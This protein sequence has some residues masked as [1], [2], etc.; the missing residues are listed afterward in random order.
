MSGHQNLLKTMYVYNF[1]AGF[2]FK[3]NLSMF[4]LV[5]LYIFVYVYNVKMHFSNGSYRE[6]MCILFKKSAIEMNI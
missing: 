4:L 1:I 3:N 5:F 6:Q 2:Y